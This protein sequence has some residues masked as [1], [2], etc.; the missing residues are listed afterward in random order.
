MESYNVTFRTYESMAVPHVAC[1]EYIAVQNYSVAL[2]TARSDIAADPDDSDGYYCLVAANMGSILRTVSGLL[3]LAASQMSA[4]TSMSSTDIKGIALVFLEEIQ[5]SIAEIDSASHAL[6]GMDSPTFTIDRFPLSMDPGSLVELFGLDEGDLPGEVDLDSE[7]YV[8]LRCTWD[9]S[10]VHLLASTLNGVQA[11]LNYA[12]GHK[13][14]LDISS[15]TSMEFTS[16]GI[17]R[18]LLH[19]PRFLNADLRDIGR[20]TGDNMYKGLDGD[21]IAMLSYLFGR[22]TDLEGIAPATDGLLAAIRASAASDVK[23]PVIRWEVDGNG[24][25]SLAS[26]PALAPLGIQS[27]YPFRLPAELVDAA[28][29]LGTDILANIEH[30]SAAVEL[31]PFLDAL[32]T[33]AANNKH[34]MESL[35]DNPSAVSRL[36]DNGVAVPNLISLNP[37]VFLADPIALRAM[38][39]YY[40]AYATEEPEGE[41]PIDYNRAGMAIEYESWLE[42]QS[43][44]EVTAAVSWITGAGDAVTDPVGLISWDHFEFDAEN[45]AS[46]VT[47]QIPGVSDAKALDLF[48]PADDVAA[49]EWAPHLVYILFQDPTFG[50]LLEVNP[51]ALNLTSDATEN[52]GFNESLNALLDHFCINTGLG[53]RAFD[54]DNYVAADW[55]AG[56]DLSKCPVW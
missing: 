13:L 49:S 44:G 20:W 22:D 28:V 43:A 46:V 51:A 40:F 34:R 35:F 4:T 16:E 42:Y 6:A 5:D 29:E 56:R 17:A 45:Y 50:G 9:L 24:N 33:Y 11:L 36:T 7:L 48:L 18:F 30:Q 39:P 25:P 19:N 12:L 23:D 38:F 10:H 37:G 41:D 47:F 54:N 15:A 52:Y 21:L 2:R 3:D 8:D 31:K 1:Q 53:W 26:I 14:E 55:A 32:Q 27:E